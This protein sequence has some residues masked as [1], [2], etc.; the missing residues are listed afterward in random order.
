MF[1]LAEDEIEGSIVAGQ[2]GVEE[3]TVVVARRADADDVE[4]MKVV[5]EPAEWL[6]KQARRV[7]VPRPWYR[8][9]REI[10]YDKSGSAARRRLVRGP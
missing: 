1:G 10:V 5:G 2:P 8:R 3:L 4:V 6:T 9:I 7:T